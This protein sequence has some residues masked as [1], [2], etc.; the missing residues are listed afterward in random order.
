M[1]TSSLEPR[2][3][4]NSVPYARIS[5]IAESV[6]GGVVNASQISVADQ[7]VVDSTGNGWD[8]PS[9]HNGVIS[10]VP[11]DFSDGVDNDSGVGRYIMPF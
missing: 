9:P 1:S 11:N 3:S 2:Q 7:V 10:K 5:Q 4:L 8:S 6:E